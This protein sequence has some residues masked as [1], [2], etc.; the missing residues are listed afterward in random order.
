MYFLLSGIV[1]KFIYLKYGLSVI[2]TFV[3]IKMVIVEFYHVPILVSLAVIIA[4][5]AASIA[6]S[7][8]FPPKAVPQPHHRTGSMFGTVFRSERSSKDQQQR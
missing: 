3:G 1:H 5:L 2:L 7:L 6:V 4:V 8:K